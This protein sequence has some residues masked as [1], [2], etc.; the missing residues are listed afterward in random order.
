[1]RYY[2]PYHPSDPCTNLEPL[3]CIG[4]T[5]DPSNTNSLPDTITWKPE[6]TTFH[7]PTMYEPVPFP[8]VRGYFDLSVNDIHPPEEDDGVSEPFPTPVKVISLDRK[9]LIMM[10]TRY[11]SLGI[12][13]KQTTSRMF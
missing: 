5:R 13:D 10:T 4:T 7:E 9:M 2:I 11:P 1:M 12:R 3:R 6:R 8:T